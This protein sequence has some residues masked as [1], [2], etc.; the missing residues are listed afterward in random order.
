MYFPTDRSPD[1]ILQALHR[2]A[3]TH[4]ACT[5]TF[6]GLMLLTRSDTPSHLKY[7]NYGAERMHESLLKTLQK[8]WSQV[9]FRQAFGTTETTNVRT[10]SDDNAYYFKPGKTGI[11]YKI[12]NDKLYLKKPPSFVK[13]ISGSPP[14]IDGWYETGDLVMEHTSGY[15]EIVGRA[16]EIIH[17]GGEKIAPAEIERVIAKVT[18]V[19]QVKVFGKPNILTGQ[20][21]C[22][23]VV[24]EH[25]TDAER[26]KKEIR[27]YCKMHLTAYKT[28]QQ[29]KII[30]QPEFNRRLKRL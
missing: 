22:A 9:Q 8:R 29:I 25:P 20:M 30:H 7:I 28:P 18:G 26:L 4:M 3:I 6:L 12:I 5:P 24:C 15:I 19:V 27:Q 11:D 23:E 13:M 21:I 1:T 10:W 17:M 14:D 16:E 2:E